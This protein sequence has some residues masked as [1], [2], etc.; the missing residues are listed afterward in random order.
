[1][2]PS[3]LVVRFGDPVTVNCSL[4]T[5]GFPLLGWE[6]SL[7]SPAPTEGHFLVWSVDKMTEWSINPMCWALTDQG[8][9]CDIN[10]PL[11]VFK[12]P[13]SVTLSLLNHT[14]PMMEGNEY[15]L[16]CTVQGV[17]P[18][19]KLSVTFYRG[20]TALVQ[21]RTSNNT[22][23]EPVNETLTWIITPSKEDDGAEYWCEAT[24]KL[25]PEGPRHPP[26]VKSKRL[27]ATVLYGPQI[28]CPPKLRVKEG[29]SLECAVRG[30]PQPL[31][32][33]FRDGEAVALPAHSNREHAG[34]YTVSAKG[35]REKNLTVMVEVL[36]GGGAANSYNRC[37]L[38]AVL[39]FQTLHWL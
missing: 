13:D 31:V 2:S 6:V 21:T 17:A 23:K 25:G 27:T 5:L 30:N 4:R 26:V 3:T 1:M 37:F 10:L 20:Q 11:I 28:D 7:A 34:Y 19:E 15:T 32:T 29:E 38:L 36:P 22:E 39:L 14:G 9:Q 24:L 8:G 16:Q 35:L 12:P 18:A 33:W